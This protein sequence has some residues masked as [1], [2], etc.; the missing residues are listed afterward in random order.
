MKK[1]K[2]LNLLS[3]LT[4]NL[5][6]AD[7]Y[8]SDKYLEEVT[9]QSEAM[10]ESINS[11]PI[12]KTVEE[13]AREE[14]FKE[15]SVSSTVETI[16][17]EYIE[18]VDGKVVTETKSIRTKVIEAEPLVERSP[19][20]KA[21]EK[22]KSEGKVIMLNIRSTD[23]KYCDK[24]EAET[25]STNSVQ[26]ALEANFI[27]IHYNQDLEPLPLGLQEGMTPN[28]IFVNTDEDI[29][30]MYPGMRTP[31]EF[32]EVLVQILAM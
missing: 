13:L 23:C 16:T 12:A 6:F 32:K 17:E 14:K 5:L 29:L 8:I 31:D 27:T 7:E 4:I 30:N 26:N 2:F 10:Y 24:M 19:Y 22:A 25:L 15:K 21:L 3:L 18:I 20:M 9:A 28:F 1:L 11:L